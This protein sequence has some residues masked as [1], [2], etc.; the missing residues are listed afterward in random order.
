MHSSAP[1]LPGTAFTSALTCAVLAL[2]AG[3]A[4]AAEP[5]QTANSGGPIWTI[6][7]ENASIST[8][9]P[10]DRYYVNGLHVGWTSAPGAVP[11]PVAALGREVWGD[12]TQRISLGLTQKIFTPYNT[13]AINP[14]LNDEPYAGYLAAT[15][16]LIQDTSTTRSVLGIDAGV[17]GPAAGAEAVQNGV[18]TIISQNHTHGWAYQLPNEPAFDLLAARIWRISLAQSSGGVE[19]DVLPQLGGMLGTT[20]IYAEP[21]VAFRFGEGLDS[22]F[23]APMLRPAPS[24]SDAYD[25]TRK[26]VWYVFGGIATKFV[27]HDEFLQGSNFQSSRSVDPYR[28]VGQ[29]ELGAAVIWHGLRFSYTQVFQTRRFYGQKGAIH[30]YGSL[31]VSARF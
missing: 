8:Q 11:T 7:E 24:G 15:F 23:G 13:Q 9:Y 18:H 6:Q 17:V 19:M 27:A 1:R 2:L 20:E 16:E 29:A 3:T 22:D 28:V 10:T 12:G 5:S 26:L 25:Q 30:E 21:S 31:A 14:P 4:A